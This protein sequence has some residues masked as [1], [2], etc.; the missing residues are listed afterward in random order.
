LVPSQ[1][2]FLGGAGWHG[3]SPFF[4][5]RCFLFPLTA[6]PF[7][8]RRMV[9][10]SLFQFARVS[11]HPTA[12]FFFRDGVDEVFCGGFSGAL[13]PTFNDEGDQFSSKQVTCAVFFSLLGSFF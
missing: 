6:L 1:L 12:F 5:V 2:F 11:F 4:D 3:G 10:V 7:P 13:F 9:F 8:T